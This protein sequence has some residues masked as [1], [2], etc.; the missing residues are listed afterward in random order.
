MMIAR[1]EIE[2][3][4]G[5]EQLVEFPEGAGKRK[6]TDESNDRDA[7]RGEQAK[8]SVVLKNI[9]TVTHERGIL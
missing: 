2:N 6:E 7:R 1:I 3:A 5:E 9:L 8:S 4:P